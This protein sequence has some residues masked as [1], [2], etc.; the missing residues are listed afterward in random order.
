MLA[1]IT[2]KKYEVSEM[3]QWGQPFVSTWEQL[4]ASSLLHSARD[5]TP[6]A[7]ST[8]FHQGLAAVDHLRGNLCSHK[9]S[10]LFPV[11]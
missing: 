1:I 2:L 6:E 7:T 8:G 10:G 4:L 3:A 11:D 9:P 5:H